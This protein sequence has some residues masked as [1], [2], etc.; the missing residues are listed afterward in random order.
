LIYL[1]NSSGSFICSITSAQIIKS[2]SLIKFEKDSSSCPLLIHFL[3]EYLFFSSD[4][5]GSVSIPIVLFS[6]KYL[7]NLKPEPQPIS[8]TSLNSFLI[9]KSFAN[10]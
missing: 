8:I 3:F 4:K 6:L 1:I 9:K 5:H 2:T 7:I 10:L